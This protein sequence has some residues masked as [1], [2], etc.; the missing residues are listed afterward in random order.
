[1]LL[2]SLHLDMSA[3]SD[4]VLV[5]LFTNAYSWQKSKYMLDQIFL[6][7]KC[8][9]IEHS[10]NF[11]FMAIEANF[12]LPCTCTVNNA[13]SYTVEV[14]QETFCFH[15]KW[16]LDY[17]EK[18]QPTYLTGGNLQK[19][20]RVFLTCPCHEIYRDEAVGIK[21]CKNTWKITIFVKMWNLGRYRENL[22]FCQ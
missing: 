11:S 18:P 15:Q 22:I 12:C 10:L 1:M 21:I 20:K 19:W 8:T 4:S 17:L 5:L 14:P 7:G 9:F 16:L 2:E 13:V 3:T 6:T